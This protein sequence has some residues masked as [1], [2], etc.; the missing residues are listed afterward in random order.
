MPT[1]A[2]RMFVPRQAP[3]WTL[4]REK[5]DHLYLKPAAEC[6]R[7][8]SGNA[9]GNGIGY[10]DTFI[11]FIDI[12]NSFTRRQVSGVGAFPFLILLEKFFSSGSDDTDTILGKIR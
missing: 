11:F 8:F 4:H 7:I 3:P 10:L 1:T 9:K 12:I 6:E 5:A 2:N